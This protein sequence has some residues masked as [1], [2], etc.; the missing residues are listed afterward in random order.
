MRKN[1]PTDVSVSKSFPGVIPPDPR[2]WERA[3][4]SWIFPQHGLRLCAGAEAPRMLRPP[5]IKNLPRIWAGYGPVNSR[6]QSETIFRREWVSEWVSLTPRP[7]QYRSFRKRNGKRCNICFISNF[8]QVLNYE[9][10]TYRLRLQISPI[11][12]S[13]E[14]IAGLTDDITNCHTEYIDNKLN[15]LIPTSW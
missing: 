12:C 5:R 3:T 6:L 14:H 8:F 11:C 2:Y 13:L 9:L 4:P 1:A 7:T 15:Y 10:I